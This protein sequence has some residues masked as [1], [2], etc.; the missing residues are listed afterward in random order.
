MYKPCLQGFE[1]E[2]VNKS[3]HL[4]SFVDFRQG[5]HSATGWQNRIS[6]KFG[7]SDIGAA[8]SYILYHPDDKLVSCPRFI[9]LIK[10]QSVANLGKQL[11]LISRYLAVT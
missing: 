11:T 3:P 5:W 8:S 4:L 6:Q 10:S 7:E 2:R 9:Y 1:L